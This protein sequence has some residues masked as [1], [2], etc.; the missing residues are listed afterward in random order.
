MRSITD[1]LLHI[2]ALFQHA[3]A[4][5]L[6]RQARMIPRAHLPAVPLRLE[7]TP[8]SP[9]PGPA[10]L[11]QQA[12][13][14][15]SHRVSRMA[16]RF[17]A[18]FA[19]WQNGTLPTSRLRA[20]R[21]TPENRPQRPRPLRLP[22]AFGWANHRLADCGAPPAAGQLENLVLN[23][24]A[25]LRPFLQAAPQA[26][27]LLRPLCQALGVRPPEYLALPPRPR[28]PRKPRPRAPRPLP[29]A[30][31]DLGLRPW[32]VAWVRASHRKYG[33]D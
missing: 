26:G 11:P 2:V 20:K 12:Y 32:V 14:L 8:A 24:A 10:P 31:P 21:P 27:R 33:R 30:H 23:R 9:P 29:L 19:R 3:I 15:L 28:P 6:T 25:E 7:H 18:L 17:L 22:R 13:V 4:A 5:H 16:R 1:H